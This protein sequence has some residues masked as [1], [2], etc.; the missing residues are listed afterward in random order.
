MTVP[1]ETDVTADVL[2]AL[3]DVVHDDVNLA[4]AISSGSFITEK[5][6]VIPCSMRSAAA[7]AYSQNS[8]LLVR[9]AEV[10]LKERRRFVLVVRETP[11]HFGHVRTL[12]QLAE[13]GAIVL[14]PVPGLYSRP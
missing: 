14:P 5:M 8:N 9:A 12:V 6:I 10:C 2:E 1:L 3:A 4:A 13:I 11:L 7:V